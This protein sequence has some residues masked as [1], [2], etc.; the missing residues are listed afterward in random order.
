MRRRA[1][2]RRSGAAEDPLTSFGSAGIL[3]VIAGGM[4]AV[5]KCPVRKGPRASPRFPVRARRRRRPRARRSPS[6]S[7]PAATRDAAPAAAAAKFV[8]ATI[9]ARAPAGRAVRQIADRVDMVPRRS[10]PLPHPGRGGRPGW[11]GRV[12]ARA[13]VGGPLTPPSPRGEREA[14]LRV[15]QHQQFEVAFGGA[16]ADDRGDE[17]A[18]RP[19]SDGGR[20]AARR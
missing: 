20:S 1:D 7:R 18:A 14:P 8:P 17:V 13:G 19:G 5:G 6:R 10:A 9:R 3:T 4:P 12:R 2:R 16:A 15:E 11:G